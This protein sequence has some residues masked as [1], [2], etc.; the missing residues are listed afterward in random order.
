MTSN[1]LTGDSG[2]AGDG[3]ERGE[4]ALVLDGPGHCEIAVRPRSRAGPGELL[5]APLAVGLCATDVE[6]LEGTMVYLRTGKSRLPLVPG[7]EWVARVLDAPAD[8][9]GPSPGDVVVGECSIGCARCAACASGAYHQCAR[10]RE[11][12]V[13]GLDGALAE[14]MVFP[15]RSAHAVPAGTS[16][17]DAVFAEPTAVA[18]RAVLRSSC[19]PGGSAL[20]VGGGTVG[21]LVSAILM[22]LVHAD[23][24][25]LEPDA[26]RMDRLRRLGV[27]GSSDG[28]RF[29]VVVEA[30]GN[31]AGLTSGLARLAPRGR[32]VVIG[33]SGGEPTPVD[34][35]RLVVDDQVLLGS[36][37]SPGVWPQALGLLGRGRVRPS[38][39]I[40]HRFPLGR[41]PEAL[42]LLRARAPGLGKVVVAPQEPDQG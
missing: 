30:S 35:D 12:G 9:R 8:T 2:P 37:G 31:P 34:V 20:V 4:R 32:C 21:W 41:A 16:V 36:L 1:A 15:A 23:V 26:D 28:E 3:P 27:R 40:T 39:L 25:A 42:Q 38:A 6:L 29:D 7:H 5:L 10:R 22:D 14:T 18:L 17:E 19:R 33:L 13:V 11:T 24:A